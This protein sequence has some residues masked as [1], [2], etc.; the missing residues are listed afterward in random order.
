M[1][2]IEIMRLSNANYKSKT[3]LPK[4]IK[5]RLSSGVKNTI[6]EVG[7][8]ERAEYL[9][10]CQKVSTYPS[11]VCGIIENIPENM[12]VEY[13]AS[14]FYPEGYKLTFKE[15]KPQHTAILHSLKANAVIE[16]DLE[17]IKRGE[18]K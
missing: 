12:L 11:G 9:K 10:L 7:N 15:G 1:R 6:I 18:E 5:E 3:Y 14:V 13:A 2:V 8:L 16:C 4:N 17:K